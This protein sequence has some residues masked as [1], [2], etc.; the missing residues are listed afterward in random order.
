MQR[1]LSRLIRFMEHTCSPVCVYHK[2]NDLGWVIHNFKQQQL[3]PDDLV[4]GEI[5]GNRNLTK[6]NASDSLARSDTGNEK[7]TVSGALAVY[8]RNVFTI[9]RRTVK[10]ALRA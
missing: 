4:P 3:Y 5:I 1:S 8:V 6:L 2:N 10:T 9:Q 7:D